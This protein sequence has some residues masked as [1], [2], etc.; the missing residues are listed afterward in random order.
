MV[1]LTRDTSHFLIRTFQPLIP[2]TSTVIRIENAEAILS[3]P[4]QCPRTTALT[5][6][7]PGVSTAAAVMTLKDQV[8]ATS[9]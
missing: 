6:A 9:L 8:S 3:N 2:I 1:H 7:G 4:C 5:L